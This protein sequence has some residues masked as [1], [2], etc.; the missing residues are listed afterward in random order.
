[1]SGRHFIRCRRLFTGLED[2]VRMDQTLVVEGG[3]FTHVG[4]TVGAPQTSANDRVTE[5]GEHFVMPG[6][7]DVH[8]H[9]VF[10]N[11]RSEEDIDFWATAE[12]LFVAGDPL[13]DVRVLLAPE[14]IASVFLGGERVVAQRRPYDRFKLTDLSSLKWTDLYTRERVAQLWRAGAGPTPAAAV[15]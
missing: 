6:L 4:P 15:T 14:A 3:V 2:D 13:A 9:L 5:A 1:V 12:F 8:T 7:I 11:A 10:G